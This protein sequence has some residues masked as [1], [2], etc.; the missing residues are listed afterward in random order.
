MFVFLL[1]A[2][3]VC[4]QTELILGCSEVLGLHSRQVDVCLYCDKIRQPTPAHRLQRLRHDCVQT[5][6]NLWLTFF[7]T[8]ETFK[9]NFASLHTILTNYIILRHFV[10]KDG[11]R[12]HLRT[13]C[14]EY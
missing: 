12:D 10:C 8:F 7:L 2:I 11:E 3:L 6:I 1:I 9:Y 14:V 13:Y 4:F 5:Q